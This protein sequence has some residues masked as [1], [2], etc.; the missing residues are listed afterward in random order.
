MGFA[1]V[2]QL[3]FGVWLIYGYYI[4]VSRTPHHSLV[5]PISTNPN[6]RYSFSAWSHLLQLRQFLLDGIQ[7]KFDH[8]AIWVDFVSISTIYLKSLFE[9]LLTLI[10]FSIFSG[11]LL[12]VCLFTIPNFLDIPI[13]E[14]RV[15]RAINHHTV[16]SE[17]HFS[18]HTVQLI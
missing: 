1:I 18:K 9:L 5:T 10:D 14:Y 17:L 12:D 8:F 4:Y 11:L 16:A 2:W 13:A 7:C 6:D 3:L 15:I